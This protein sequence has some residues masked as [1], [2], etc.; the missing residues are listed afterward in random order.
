MIHD[1]IVEK[2][3]HTN[4]TAW[5]CAIDAYIVYCALKEAFERYSKERIPFAMAIE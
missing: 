4:S 1:H 5:K 2:P 3:N